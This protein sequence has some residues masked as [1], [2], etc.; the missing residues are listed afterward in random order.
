MRS[1]LYNPTT[2]VNHR[3]DKLS[4]VL[5]LPRGRIKLS[6]L[7]SVSPPDFSFIP[8]FQVG[9]FSSKINK[10]VRVLTVLSTHVSV[11]NHMALVASSSGTQ[12]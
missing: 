5:L 9:N 11:G 4:E 8:I 2:R 1:D 10:I 12:V 3:L 7:V 6:Y